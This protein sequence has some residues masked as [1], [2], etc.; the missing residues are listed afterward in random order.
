MHRLSLWQETHFNL[1][2]GRSKRTPHR[3]REHSLA[4]ATVQALLQNL[5]RARDVEAPAGAGA[6]ALRVK[7]SLALHDLGAVWRETH[8]YATDC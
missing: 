4:G 1:S 2:K 8:Q 3:L 6:S 5:A 7:E